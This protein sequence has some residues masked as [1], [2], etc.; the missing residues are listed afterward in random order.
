[1]RRNLRFPA[2]QR[3]RGNSS[4]PTSWRRLAHATAAVPEHNSPYPTPLLYC[5][6]LQQTSRGERERG[7]KAQAD[8]RFSRTRVRPGRNLTV[9][10]GRLLRRL[11]DCADTTFHS[12]MTVLNKVC[13]VLST[14]SRLSG[15]RLLPHTLG[16]A[17]SRTSSVAAPCSHAFSMSSSLPA[18]PSPEAFNA[19]SQSSRTKVYCDYGDEGKMTWKPHNEPPKVRQGAGL[20]SKLETKKLENCCPPGGHKGAGA[21]RL[22]GTYTCR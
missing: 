9:P 16:S 8:S 20:L 7:E 2:Q 12:T 22:V 13:F 5:A 10:S 17:T 4:Q 14:T 1:M 6:R 11:R 3:R 18:W 15:R 19:L 21:G